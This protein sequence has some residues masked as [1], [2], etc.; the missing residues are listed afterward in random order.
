MELVSG[1]AFLHPAFEL[2]VVA[3]VRSLTNAQVVDAGLRLMIDPKMN[4]SKL[5]TKNSSQEISESDNIK[6]QVQKGNS[7]YFFN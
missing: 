6:K 3:V 1:S 2:A 7:S 5:I 4:K